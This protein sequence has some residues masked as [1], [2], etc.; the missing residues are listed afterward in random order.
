MTSEALTRAAKGGPIESFG[1]LSSGICVQ[2]RCPTRTALSPT[3]HHHDEQPRRYTLI[4]AA[5]KP[6]VIATSRSQR[7]PTS[8]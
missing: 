7:R 2:P 8:P 1:L 4:D 5:E 6:R 3:S